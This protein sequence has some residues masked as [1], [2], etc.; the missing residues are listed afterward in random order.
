MNNILLVE[1]IDNKITVLSDNV[2]MNLLS[3]ILNI[4]TN[5]EKKLKFDKNELSKHTHKL[6][7]MG[8]KC[9]YLNNLSKL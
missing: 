8:Y 9:Y 5:N 1:G 3:D 7:H 2:S 6:T 4:K